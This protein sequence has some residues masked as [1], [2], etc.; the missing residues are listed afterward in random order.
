MPMPITEE[1]LLA[2]IALVSEVIVLH[3]PV[4]APILDRLERE[5]EVLQR[6][7]DPTTRARRHLERAAA[8]QVAY[9]FGR[10]ESG[11]VL[12]NVVMS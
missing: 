5:L 2:A 4:Y 11:S 1:R 12:K 10:T 7:N 9:S 6:G 8:T 3:G